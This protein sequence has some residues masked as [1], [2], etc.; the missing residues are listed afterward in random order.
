VFLANDGV[1][2]ITGGLVG[3]ASAEVINLTTNQDGFIKK[4][5]PD[6]HAKA[7][8]VFSEKLREYQLYVPFDGNDRPNKG[9]VLHVDRLPL[10]QTVSPWST[11]EG[12]PVGAVSTFFDGTV[13]FGHNTGSQDTT[14]NSQRG[15]FV[16]SGL[17]AAGKVPSGN[18]LVY[19]DLPKSVYRAAW[20][21]FGDPQ[22][23]KQVNY[24]TLWLMT[25]GNVE[26][27]VRHYK[28]FSLTP[29][30]ERTY[31]AQPPDAAKQPVLDKAIIGQSNFSD[32][33]L[34]PLRV[35]VAHQSAAWFCF[36]VE[37][38]AELTIVGYEYEYQSKG[39]KVIAGVRA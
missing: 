27:T 3:G 33:R 25:T 24:V 11:R 6:C 31:F 18:T 13:I 1:Y 10:I 29:T 26:V 15:L 20:N 37:T 17:R 5:T 21:N 4:I 38:D 8:A 28:D 32:E 35:S 14:P 23:Q 36:E 39:T 34:V 12:F 7:V 19:A 30:E 22:V 9:F 16:I 2:A